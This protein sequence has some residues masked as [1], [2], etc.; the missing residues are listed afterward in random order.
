MG[1]G[2]VQY[3]HKTTVRREKICKLLKCWVV[4]KVK[5]HTFYSLK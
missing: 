3:G 5:V 2:I 4:A 1:G